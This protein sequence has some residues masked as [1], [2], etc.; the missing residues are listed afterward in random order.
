MYSFWMDP[1]GARG[2][3]LYSTDDCASH[4]GYAASAGGDNVGAGDAF[5]AVLTLAALA[6][7]PLIQTVEA[8]NRVGSF[9][10]SHR[11]ATP[12]IPAW[13]RSEVRALLGDASTFT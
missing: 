1:H 10:A 6:G 12:E 4:P 3:T 5:T 13:L 2:A 8:A 11:G 7:T 9:I